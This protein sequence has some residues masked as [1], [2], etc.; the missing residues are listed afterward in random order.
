[1]FLVRSGVASVSYFSFSLLFVSVFYYALLM[2]FAGMV[3]QAAWGLSVCS[4]R[5]F[6]N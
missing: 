3:D 6:Y 4:R 1:M 5:T 2:C